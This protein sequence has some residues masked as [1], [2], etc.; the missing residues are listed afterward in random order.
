MIPNIHVESCSLNGNE[1]SLGRRLLE[2]WET[3]YFCAVQPKSTM[4]ARKR[5]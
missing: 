4:T 1:A 3:K 2:M 5:G